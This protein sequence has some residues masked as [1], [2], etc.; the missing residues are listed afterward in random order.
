MATQKQTAGAKI[1]T[2]KKPAP[3]KRTTKKPAPK[4]IQPE[5]TTEKKSTA[6]TPKTKDNANKTANDKDV[7]RVIAKINN[8]DS[9]TKATKHIEEPKTITDKRNCGNCMFFIPTTKSN[10]PMLPKSSKGAGEKA[11]WVCNCKDCEFFEKGKHTDDCLDICEHFDWRYE[12]PR[13]VDEWLE[14]LYHRKKTKILN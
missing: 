9:I 1:P 8:S 12:N 5:K 13:K 6:K 11:F 4:K 2:T 14:T 10:P 3:K 7:K